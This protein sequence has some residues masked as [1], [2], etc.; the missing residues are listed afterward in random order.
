MK[1]SIKEAVGITTTKTQKF[2]EFRTVSMGKNLQ[3]PTACAWNREVK[4][5]D[6]NGQIVHSD[7]EIP[8]CLFE[9][10]YW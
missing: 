8:G 10:R 7:E 6:Q 2:V 4:D 1:E 9:N 5:C 3:Q